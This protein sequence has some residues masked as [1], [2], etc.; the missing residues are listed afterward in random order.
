VSSRANKADASKV[1]PWC[2]PAHL[3][4][5]V[6]HEPRVHD[7]AAQCTRETCTSRVHCEGCGSVA[8]EVRHRAIDGRPWGAG[9]FH[10][11]FPDG[12]W[13]RLTYAG[14]GAPGVLTRGGPPTVVSG[15]DHV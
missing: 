9:Y 14:N 6:M 1:P 8:T 12:E 7:C 15:G 4:R 3:H 10:V 13:A 5:W 2:D 11:E